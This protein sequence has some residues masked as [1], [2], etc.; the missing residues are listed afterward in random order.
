MVQ[1]N[2]ERMMQL[3]EK[4]FA[5]KD[6]PEQLDVD[7]DVIERLRRL[8]PAT[9]SVQEDANGP[10]AW[11][12]VIPTTMELMSRFL[13]KEISEKE[14]FELTPAGSEYE[15]VY[16]CSALVLDEYRRKGIAG[17]LALSAIEQIRRDH[18]LK[19]LFV[20][21]FTEEGDLAAQAIARKVGLP[22]YKRVKDSSVMP[23]PIQ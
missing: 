20:W 4:V 16:L 3:A 11:V 23:E 21:T 22:L 8:H 2:L 1:S 15:A 7:Q 5:V 18:P 9:V 14:L 6:D 13:G 10:V 12:L 19:A 17:K